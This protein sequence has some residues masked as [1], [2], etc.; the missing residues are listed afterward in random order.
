[1]NLT[2]EEELRLPLYPAVY[3]FLMKP[4]NTNKKTI[5]VANPYKMQ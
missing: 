1:M 2:K 4:D 3:A 5:V